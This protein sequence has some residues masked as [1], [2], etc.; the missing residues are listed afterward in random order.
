MPD[1]PQGMLPGAPLVKYVADRLEPKSEGGGAAVDLTL[2]NRTDQPIEVYWVDFAGKEIP[3]HALPPYEDAQQGTYVGHLWREKQGGRVVATYRATTEPKQ[4]FLLYAHPPGADFFASFPELKLDPMLYTGKNEAILPYPNSDWLGAGFDV[5]LADPANFADVRT[6]AD[7]PRKESALVLTLS[8]RRSAD[9]RYLLPYGVRLYSSSATRDED[10]ERVVSSTE[11]L[12]TTF[13]LNISQ[14]LD[15]G[16]AAFS[17]SLSYS[18]VNDTATGRDHI[19]FLQ[20]SVLRNDRLSL[21]LTWQDM[22]DRWNRQRLAPDFQRRV[23]Q[24][25]QECNQGYDQIRQIYGTHYARSVQFGGQYNKLTKISKSSFDSFTGSQTDFEQHLRLTVPDTPVT[26]SGGLAVGSGSSTARSRSDEF[27]DAQVFAS[28]GVG[29]SDES[30]WK[31]SVQTAPVPVDIEF[32]P[33]TDLLNIAFFPNDPSVYDKQEKMRQCFEG[34]FQE[35]GQKYADRTTADAAPF[36]VKNVPEE[37]R[38]KK[39]DYSYITEVSIVPHPAVC[40]SLQIAVSTSGGAAEYVTVETN[41]NQDAIAD[42]YYLCLKRDMKGQPITRIYPIS[43]NAASGQSSCNG[44]D[45]RL[46]QNVN[47]KW[48]SFGQA[49]YICFGSDPGE[50]PLYDVTIRASV[51][52]IPNYTHRPSSAGM[53]LNAGNVLLYLHTQDIRQARDAGRV[54]SSQIATAGDIEIE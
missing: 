16:I 51:G 52:N 2:G 31:A 15:V 50:Y 38:K 45:V 32:A 8:D 29:Y 26:A 9:G 4:R 6:G 20:R 27:S 21:D 41:L 54:K 35:V 46:Q 18:N 22:S 33:Y 11:D 7:A 47:E 34:Y 48:N 53:V 42:S 37:L 13:S 14:A 43:H 49:N 19:Y 39:P 23:E 30:S 25:G 40:Q 1:P 28:G 44:D 12:R 5:T 3:Y 36:F 24:L 10:V 17:R